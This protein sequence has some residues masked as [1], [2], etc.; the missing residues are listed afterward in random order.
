LCHFIKRWY[1][2]L[3]SILTG[4]IEKYL[5]RLGRDTIEIMLLLTVLLSSLFSSYAFAPV[6]ELN[7]TAYLGR[8]YQAY[9]DLAVEATF[10]NSSYCVTADYGMNDNNTVSVA[11]LE[12]QYSIDGPVRRVL[13]WAAQDGGGTA[14]GELTVHL[15]TV[16]F[17]APYWIFE[18]GP[19]IGGEYQYSVV[20]DPFKLTLFVLARNLTLFA[21]EWVS[22]V[23]QR[24]ADA[25]YTRVLNTPIATIQEGCNYS[26]AF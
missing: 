23:L 2:I 22:G 6:T 15:Q 5:N 14:A 3:K 26:L 4:K 12:R 10:E 17:G 11:N 19:V 8:W 20:S 21:G 16:E 9:S 7:R 25:G 1:F 24:L 13:G 18:L